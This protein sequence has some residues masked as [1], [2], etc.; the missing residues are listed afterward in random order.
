MEGT[1]PLLVEFQALVAPSPLGTPRR[2][3]VGWDNARLAMVLAVLEA[4]AGVKLGQYDIYLNVAG[5]LR[6][7]EPA[8]DVAAA[9]ALVSSLS[10]MS[11]AA[12]SVFFGEIALSGTIRPVAHGLARL[13]EAAK[14]GFCR[15]T[16][17]QGRPENGETL[18]QDL[19]V[20]TCTHISGL[21]AE[22]VAG[23]GQ[24][25]QGPKKRG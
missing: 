16:I 18:V 11:L 20:Q 1:R 14:L 10:G 3:V 12:D 25:N 4:H 13:K 23:G 24:S 8:A 7:G 2:A 15:A 19:N 21:T 22:I 6:V 17:P 9:A 5:G